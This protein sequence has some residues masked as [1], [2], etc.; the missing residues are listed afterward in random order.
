MTSQ[1]S[2][3]RLARKLQLFHNDQSPTPTLQRVT[4]D[5]L[6]DNTIRL[7]AQ[8]QLKREIEWLNRNALCRWIIDYIA[9]RFTIV[10]FA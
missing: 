4:A 7:I 10:Q 5:P 1:L 8:M 2:T 6:G 3:N 9:N